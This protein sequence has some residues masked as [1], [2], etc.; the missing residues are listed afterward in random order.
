MGRVHGTRW[1]GVWDGT[2]GHVGRDE[3]GMWDRMVGCM[4]REPHDG[5]AIWGA[6]VG[7][8]GT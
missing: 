4:G 3:W 7:V 5:R 1:V 6:P 8:F 2:A